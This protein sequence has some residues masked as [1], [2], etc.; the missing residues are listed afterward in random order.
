MAISQL[1]KELYIWNS[2]LKPIGPILTYFDLF[3]LLDPFR[4]HFTY[5]DL[6]DL[7]WP[8][9]PILTYG[10]YFYTK[11][12]MLGLAPSNTEEGAKGPP[13]GPPA[14][15]RTYKEGHG[16][17]QTSN[18]QIISHFIISLPKYLDI[19]LNRLTTFMLLKI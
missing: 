10:T 6:F 11:L 1:F 9:W 19:K 5:F 18:Y 17:S 16:A 4:S 15:H 7:Y 12:S 2:K 13:K 8:L 14:L 3:D